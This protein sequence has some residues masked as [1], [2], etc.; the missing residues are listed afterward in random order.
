MCN[1]PPKLARYRLRRLSDVVDRFAPFQHRF[2]PRQWEVIL[3]YFGD[4]LSQDAIAKE[5]GTRRSAV[6][7][8]LRRAIKR[9]DRI[10]R[11]MRLEAFQAA[12]SV[13]L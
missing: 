12:R 9:M 7:G 1:Y 6:S 4:G 2:T 8:R 3:L 11:E 13:E 5:I 10:D